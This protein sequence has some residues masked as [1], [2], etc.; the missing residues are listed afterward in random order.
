[1]EGA[2]AKASRLRRRSFRAF[3]ESLPHPSRCF[4]RVPPEPPGHNKACTRPPVTEGLLLALLHFSKNTRGSIPSRFP[5][6][7]GTAL[8]FAE[9]RGGGLSMGPGGA[10]GLPPSFAESFLLSGGMRSEMIPARKWRDSQISLHFR[11]VG[12]GV[13]RPIRRLQVRGHRADSGV[14]KGIGAVWSIIVNAVCPGVHLRSPMWEEMAKWL[15]ESF[16]AL[17]GK[18]PQEILKAG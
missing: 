12:G 11:E 10:A 9:S 13:H 16:P 14:G 5:P 18:T 17:A 7:A 4:R 15:R 1:M 2:G 6:G 3:S 8:C